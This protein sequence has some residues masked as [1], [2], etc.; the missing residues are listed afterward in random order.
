[1]RKCPYCLQENTEEAK[2]CKHCGKDMLRAC[3]S[4]SAQIVATA[5]VCRFCSARLDTAPAPDPLRDL[6]CGDRREILLLVV[7]SV[8]TCGFYLLVLQYRI[9]REINAHLGKN[10]INPGLD[11]LLTFLTC[12]FWV[13]YMMY[14][15]PT[16]LEEML[17]EE[18]EAPPDLVLPC[19]FF[20]FM[21]LH[22]VSLLILQGELNRHWEKHL[23]A[24]A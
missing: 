4:C 7:L 22:V 8:I 20:T 12:G 10:R 3:P 1:M 24:Q 16:Q 21:G 6:P 9:G 18:G 11:V 13:F 5:K 19:L 14:R 17:R 2:L 15:Y 23:A